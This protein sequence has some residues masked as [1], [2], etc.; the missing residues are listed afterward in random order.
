MRG[1][2]W[3]AAGVL[4]AAT[5]AG[6]QE[7]GGKPPKPPASLDARGIDAWISQYIVPDGWVLLAADAAAVTYGRGELAVMEDGLVQADVRREY[8]RPARMGAMN[9]RSNQQTWLVD[10]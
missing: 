2:A 3:V 4:V 8:F 1:W 10:C 9:S 5:G 7:P 6:A